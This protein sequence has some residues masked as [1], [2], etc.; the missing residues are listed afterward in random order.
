MKSLIL[1]ILMFVPLIVFGQD[2][3]APIDTLKKEI[4]YLYRG[5]FFPYDSGVAISDQQY[6]FL[7]RSYAI[8]SIQNTINYGTEKAPKI[9]YVNTP[10]R[11]KGDS[12]KIVWFFTGTAAGI[13]ICALIKVVL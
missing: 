5:N 1:F 3:E 6:Q 8:K 12:N 2:K 11:N 9:V 10:V 4:Q 13:A 7:I